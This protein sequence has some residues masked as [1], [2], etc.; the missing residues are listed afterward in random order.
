MLQDRNIQSS[1]SGMLFLNKKNN[2]RQGAWEAKLNPPIVE[3]LVA[4]LGKDPNIRRRVQRSQ[5]QLR[6]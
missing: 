4:F 3:A 2:V 5:G 6:G 1:A